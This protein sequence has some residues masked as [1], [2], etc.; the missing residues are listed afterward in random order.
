M[1]SSNTRYRI[2]NS[3]VWTD[4]LLNGHR[5]H[6]P[7]SFLSFTV[8][9]L[10]FTA[11]KNLPVHGVARADLCQFTSVLGR[12]YNY[13]FSPFDHPAKRRTSTRDLLLHCWTCTG[14]SLF[15]LARTAP[16]TPGYN[17]RID[18]YYQGKSDCA[19]TIDASLTNNTYTDRVSAVTGW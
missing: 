17:H 15:T 6:F 2:R 4:L 5:C 16:P 13:R 1:E 9:F 12:S 3:L 18:K 10:S 19:N 8:S 11:V 14:E 7:V